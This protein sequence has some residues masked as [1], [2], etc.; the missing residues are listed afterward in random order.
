MVGQAQA[1]RPARHPLDEV[2]LL[3]ELGIDL[4]IGNVAAGGNVD[5]LEPDPAVEPNADVAGL[6]IG[7]PVVPFLLRAGKPA[8]DRNAMVHALAAEGLVDVAEAAEHRGREIRVADLGLLQAQDVG[9]FLAQEFL[10]DLDP[11]ADGIDV[12]GRDLEALGHGCG[13]NR[14]RLSCR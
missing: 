7:L 10:D 9:R 2:E 1:S 3:A 12:P 5:V 13:S 14:T 8:E 6:A 11:G 4:A